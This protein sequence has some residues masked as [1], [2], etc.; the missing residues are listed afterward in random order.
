MQER[1]NQYN[2]RARPLSGDPLNRAYLALELGLPRTALDDV[3]LQSQVLVFGGDGARLELELLLMLGRAY[4]ARDKLNDPELLR[5]K[6]KLALATVGA[7]RMAGYQPHYRLP[8]YDWLRFL[9]T[10]ATGDY[11][12]ADET[13]SAMLNVLHQ[14][15]QGGMTVVRNALSVIVATDAALSAQPMN[16]F[17]QVMLQRDLGQTTYALGDLG[18]LAAQRADLHAVSGLLA[19][20]RGAPAAA[21]KDFRAAFAAAAEHGPTMEFATRRLASVYRLQI[22]R[23]QSAGAEN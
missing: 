20:E 8:A 1:K 15:Y 14:K 4:A 22:Q 23:A 12:A 10:A 5:N 19:V 9:Q 3:L 21:L 11:D 13:L 7:P 2:L 18:F 6:D 16:K 17:Q